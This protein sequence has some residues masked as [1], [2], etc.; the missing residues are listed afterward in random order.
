[1][2]PKRAPP[3]YVFKCGSCGTYSTTEQSFWKFIPESRKAQIRQAIEREADIIGAFV[4]FGNV[5]PKCQTKKKW[6]RAEFGVLRLPS[7]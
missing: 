7:A 1:M 5:C 2:K 3:V 4:R 6:Q